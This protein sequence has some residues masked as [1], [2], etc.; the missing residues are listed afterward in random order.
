MFPSGSVV[1]DIPNGSLSTLQY[2]ISNEPVSMLLYYA[3][4]CYVSRK[5]A[6]HFEQAAQT[7]KGEVQ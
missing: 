2:V 5:T 7:L 3:P 4:W 6:R 1:L